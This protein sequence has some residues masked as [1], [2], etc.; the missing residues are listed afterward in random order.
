MAHQHGL[1]IRARRMRAPRHA[2]DVGV[3]LET[4]LPGHPRNKTGTQVECDVLLVATRQVHRNVPVLQDAGSA[5]YSHGPP[6]IP[7]PTREDTAD[8]GGGVRLSPTGG[9]V[10]RLDDLSG[11]QV[12]LGYLRSNANQPVIIGALFHSHA[13]TGPHRKTQRL[14]DTVHQGTATAI[15]D[16]GSVLVD[17]R[18]AKAGPGAGIFV[19]AGAGQ[20]V[21]LT[22]GR[23]TLTL[24]GDDAGGALVTH[25]A[26]FQLELAEDGGVVLRGPRTLTV[27]V[28]GGGRVTVAADSVEVAAPNVA[29]VETSSPVEPG[30][31]RVLA[32]G[33]RY[34]RGGEELGVWLK[35]LGTILR[36]LTVPGSSVVTPD[37]PINL[38]LEQLLLRLA[39]LTGSA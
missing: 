8:P 14:R 39:K 20:Q 3:V 26:G 28:I 32:E 34:E 1:T 5:R 15:D 9:Q 23:G 11:S 38:P 37:G 17:I 29:L 31:V 24:R 7:V 13:V 22:Q 21:Q 25:S 30:A 6:Q 10:S 33:L 19:R 27:R 4:Y 36:D 12:I 18:Q 2:L 35:D 16:G